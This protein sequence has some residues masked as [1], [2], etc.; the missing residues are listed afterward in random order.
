MAFP[1]DSALPKDLVTVNPHFNASD[2]SPLLAALKANLIAW[3]PV[4]THPFTLKAYDAATPPPSYPL[5]TESQ[6]GVAA[7]SAG[8]RE[9]ALCLSYF[10]TYNRPRFRGRLF[11][12]YTWLGG[13]PGMRPTTTQMDNALG[14]APAVLTKNLPAQANWVV[15]STVEKKSKGG[16]SDIWVDDEWDTM[17]SRG[18]EPTT[19]VTAKA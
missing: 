2:P 14:F 10:T 1:F 7:P 4:S 11:L 6:L 13:Q 15:W 19:R 16:V 5:A 8:P 3:T 9:L 12:P 17:R 18:L